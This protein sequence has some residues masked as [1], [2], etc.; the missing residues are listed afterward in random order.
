MSLLNI[1]MQ[2]NS[3]RFQYVHVKRSYMFRKCSLS[4]ATM[5]NVLRIYSVMVT[6]KAK[7]HYTSWFGASSELAN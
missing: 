7:F 5:T 3:D 4:S 6:V 2:D 1:S